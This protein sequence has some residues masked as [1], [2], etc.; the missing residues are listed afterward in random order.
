MFRQQCDTDSA[1]RRLKSHAQI[2]CY[3]PR[4]Q[5][6]LLRPIIEI[7]QL[8]EMT[9]KR[10]KARASLRSGQAFSISVGVGV[11]QSNDALKTDA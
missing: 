5:F 3:K 2:T 8:G 9:L 10:A 7:G 6:D 1:Y 4:L 11:P